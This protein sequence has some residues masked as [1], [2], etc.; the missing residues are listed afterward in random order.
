MRQFSETETA[1]AREGVMGNLLLF[2]FGCG[3]L[4]FFA[5]IDRVD[6]LTIRPVSGSSAAMAAASTRVQP[7]G[8][9]AARPVLDSAPDDRGTP[10]SR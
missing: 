4:A 3:V 8:Q 1:T 6:W 7:A 2:V 10:Q 9:E 5:S